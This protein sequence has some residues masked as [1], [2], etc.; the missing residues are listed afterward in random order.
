[1][2]I[3]LEVALIDGPLTLVGGNLVT[4]HSKDQNVVARS[5]SGA[6]YRAMAQLNIELWL[7]LF[8]RCYGF[9]LSFVT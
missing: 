4:W 7:I 5:S 6:E 3:G 2:L 8:L 1:M 9:A